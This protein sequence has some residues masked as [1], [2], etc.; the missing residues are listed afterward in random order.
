[1]VCNFLK[2][3]S[4]NILAIFCT[5]REARG[6]M[7]ELRKAMVC[8]KWD[9]CQKCESYMACLSELEKR[10]EKKSWST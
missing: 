2:D 4:G 10:K 9:I 3:S 6:I 5:R 7:G 1:M 8:R